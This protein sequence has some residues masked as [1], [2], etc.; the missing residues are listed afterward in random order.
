MK[1]KYFCLVFLFF[2]LI[3]PFFA[4]EQQSV[5][6]QLPL[7]SEQ[8]EEEIVTEDEM[9]EPGNVE[10]EIIDIKGQEF[11]TS[12]SFSEFIRSLDFVADLGPAMYINTHSKDVDLDNHLVCAPSP[13]VY[14]FSWGILW[15]NYT[16][17]AIE[18]QMAFFQ[19]YYL[20]YD[21][22]TLP[23]EIENRT[24]WSLSFMVSLPVVFQ[25]YMRNSRFQIAGGP[26]ALLRTGLLPNGVSSDDKGFSG[27]AGSDLNLINQS[28][29]A[30]GEYFY[31][32]A[33]FSWLRTVHRNVKVGPEAKLYIPVVSI[34][35][36]HGLQGMVAH[37][38]MKISL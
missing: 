16:F 34:I 28:F 32:Y 33:G 37:V 26:A 5:T 22:M 4:Q 13:I 30:D 24:C 35:N 25:L 18:P 20:W 17:V 38:A 8:T 11:T 10:D 29:Y 3:F 27:S 31:L 14:P 19:M 6:E 36:G 12:E 21:G 1:K 7:Q 2:S 23:A 15:P 9:V